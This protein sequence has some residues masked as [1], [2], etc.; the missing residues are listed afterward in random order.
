MSDLHQFL[1]E[2]AA[3]V[4]DIAA[5]V[6][7]RYELTALQ[8]ELDA[9]EEFDAYRRDEASHRDRHGVHQPVSREDWLDARREALHERMRERR[10][11]D[12]ASHGGSLGLITHF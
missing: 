5:P 6:S 9:Y 3:M 1:H 2:H 11:R 12:L 8:H 4:W 10:E 7:A